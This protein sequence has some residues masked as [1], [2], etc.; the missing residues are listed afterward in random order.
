MSDNDNNDNNNN[1]SPYMQ[2]VTEIRPDHRPRIEKSFHSI[3]FGGIGAGAGAFI[4]SF[5]IPIVGTYIGGAIGGGLGALLGADVD[6][7]EAKN[8]GYQ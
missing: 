1:V 4:G 8:Y 2:R 5:I 7:K 6:G 3:M